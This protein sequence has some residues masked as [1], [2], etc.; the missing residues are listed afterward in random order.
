[1]AT[2][3]HDI[4]V[5]LGPSLEVEAARDILDACYLPPAEQG[6]IVR[7]V[8]G[9]EPRVIALI[10]G[11]FANVPAVR[12]KEILW[13]MSKGVQVIGAA[14]IGAIRAAELNGFGMGGSGFIYRWYRATVGAD[15]DEV[16]VAM[17]PV[18]MGA[19]PLSEALINIRLTLRR[20][21]RMGAI[22]KTMYASLI[23]LARSL[24]FRSR[25]YDRI[26]EVAER[27]LPVE[28]RRSLPALSD[29]IAGHAINQKATDTRE[30]LLALSRMDPDLPPPSARSR[31]QLTDAWLADLESAGLQIDIDC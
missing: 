14:S 17:S 19:R 7:A 2:K 10:D 28:L 12:H 15:D 9:L 29:W 5:F 20:A 8:Q 18:E 22:N 26:F 3:K 30:L 31:F 23:E 13:A 21:T 4:V 1:M 27:A 25:T 6:A 24:D 11:S 16:A